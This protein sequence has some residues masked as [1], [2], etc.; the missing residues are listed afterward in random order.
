MFFGWLPM[1]FAVLLTFGDAW[2]RIFRRSLQVTAADDATLFYRFAPMAVLLMLQ[3]TYFV[4]RSVDFTL[5]MSLLSYAAIA[6]PP[7]LAGTVVGLKGRW[8]VSTLGLLPAVTAILAVTFTNVLLFR[9]DASY[10]LLLHECRD[11]RRCSP[12]SLVQG[13]DETIHIRPSLEHVP[14]PVH[15]GA[16]DNKFV[17]RG[18]ARPDFALGARPTAG[19]DAAGYARRRSP[20][21]RS[22][23]DVFRKVGSLAAFLY[24]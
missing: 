2:T 6:I 22:H 20:G 23:T 10:S 5:G 8:P 4:E 16:F 17:L 3:L 9:Q 19:D 1:F 12:A 18:R 13:L 21:V 15:D 11:A 7:T 24:T 14:R